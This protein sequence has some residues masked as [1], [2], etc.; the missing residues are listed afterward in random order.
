M[1]NW[2]TLS[3]DRSVQGLKLFLCVSVHTL[4]TLT[5]T[6]SSSD[7]YESSDYGN[8]PPA[9]QKTHHTGVQKTDKPKQKKPVPS[10]K[11]EQLKKA[12][13]AKRKKREQRLTEQASEQQKP[14]PQIN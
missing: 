4:K 11:L 8:E 1:L 3:G 7:E 5:R 14:Q 13:E 2:H 6:M 10:S 9:P 12:R